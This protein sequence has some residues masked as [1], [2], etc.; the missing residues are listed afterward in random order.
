MVDVLT[1]PPAPDANPAPVNL[2]ALAALKADIMAAMECPDHAIVDEILQ[3]ATENNIMDLG[4][5]ALAFPEISDKITGID[6]GM[7]RTP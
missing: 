5:L 3:L 4:D 2:F 6:D 7:T 1:N